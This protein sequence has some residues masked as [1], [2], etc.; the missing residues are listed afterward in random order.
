MKESTKNAIFTLISLVFAG[1]VLVFMAVPNV[2]LGANF[3]SIG[4]TVLEWSGF[5]FY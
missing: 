2:T 5:S 4:G 3:G 1:L